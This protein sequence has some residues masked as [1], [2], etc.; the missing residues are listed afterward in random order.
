MRLRTKTPSPARLRFPPLLRHLQLRWTTHRRLKKTN[1]TEDTK[2]S[3]TGSES[4]VRKRKNNEEAF[5][6]QFSSSARSMRRWCSVCLVL[7]ACTG[8]PQLLAAALVT[9]EEVNSVR[10]YKQ[11]AKSTVLVA[12]AYVSPHHIT[13]GLG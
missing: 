11:M 3:T 1:G 9:P 8:M 13:E 6:R 5:M 2:A 12:S 7:A 4:R 10:V